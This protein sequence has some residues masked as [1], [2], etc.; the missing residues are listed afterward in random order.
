MA[1]DKT[2]TAFA[3]PRTTLD[4]LRSTARDREISVSELLR[5][6]VRAY[7]TAPPPARMD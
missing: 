7:L 2:L 5:R 6:A 1:P 4:E 3:L